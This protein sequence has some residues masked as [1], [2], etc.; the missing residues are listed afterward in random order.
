MKHRK[1]LWRL[2][3]KRRVL[4]IAFIKNHNRFYAKGRLYCE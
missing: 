2:E 3:W 1:L 4:W